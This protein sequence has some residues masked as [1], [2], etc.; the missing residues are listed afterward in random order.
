[1]SVSTRLLGIAVTITIV[2]VFAYYRYEY[3]GFSLKL[4]LELIVEIVLA[5]EFIRTVVSK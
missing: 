2:G 4:W 1:V 3:G 5:A